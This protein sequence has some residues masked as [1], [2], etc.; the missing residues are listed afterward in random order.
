MEIIE[1]LSGSRG[2]ATGAVVSAGARPLNFTFKKPSGIGAAKRCSNS[3]E[4][5]RA[6]SIWVT[7]APEGS[8]FRVAM[9]E[10]HADAER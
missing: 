8:E 3:E 5:I 10:L 7:I 1:T 6:S 2:I 4:P 9:P